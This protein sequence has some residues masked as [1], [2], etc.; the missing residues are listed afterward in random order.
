M[1]AS[2][3]RGIKAEIWDTPSIPDAAPNPSTALFQHHPLS[4]ITNFLLACGSPFLQ[5]CFSGF[6]QVRQYFSASP[7]GTRMPPAQASE[8]GAAAFPSRIRYFRSVFSPDSLTTP[9]RPTPITP[10]H[11]NSAQMIS[12][13]RPE[14]R[15]GELLLSS[16]PAAR[17]AVGSPIKKKQ[18]ALPS[19]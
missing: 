15:Q 6:F 2:P 18:G 4:Q 10:R 7:K 17:P 19:S 9:T 12:I 1:A 16:P 5:T 3:R 8:P 11:F 13:E 14:Y